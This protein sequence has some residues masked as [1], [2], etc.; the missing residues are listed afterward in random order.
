MRTVTKSKIFYPTLGLIIAIV[1][2]LWGQGLLIKPK[3]SISCG[4]INYNI[5]AQYQMEIFSWKMMMSPEEL[6]KEI[7]E[8]LSA[9]LRE[10]GFSE[11]RIKLFLSTIEKKNKQEASSKVDWKPYEQN[12]IKA[13]VSKMNAELLPVVMQKYME[14]PDGALF[15]EIDNNGWVSAN[16]PH[17]VIR[18]AGAAFKKHVVC[19]EQKK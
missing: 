3:V 5:P 10:H 1:G 12:I 17:V 2:L 13:A 15:F 7:V 11:E 6:Q 4:A 8:K 18:L 16:N 9:S 19:R 14:L